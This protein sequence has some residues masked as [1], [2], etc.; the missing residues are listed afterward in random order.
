M[1][2]KFVFISNRVSPV[3][4]AL[5]EEFPNDFAS[6]VLVARASNS[7][8][9]VDSA[10]SCLAPVGIPLFVL[11]E[12]YLKS[13]LFLSFL[14]LLDL[15]FIVVHSLHFLLPRQVL[16]A[17]RCCCLNL[18]PSLL[19]AYRGPNPW[20][21]QYYDEQKTSGFTVHKMTSQEDAGDIILQQ[22]FPM[23]YTMMQFIFSEKM[24]KEVGAPLLCSAIRN[25]DDITPI[26]QTNPQQY[27][28]ARNI[29][30]YQN[31]PDIKKMTSHQIDIIRSVYPDFPINK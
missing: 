11:T 7:Q 14:Q 21:W 16:E 25:Y 4:P 29:V 27:R 18:H 22:E 15:D 10:V 24:L 2:R 3:L 5:A 20:F 1:N 19:P 26:H 6:F 23:D 9:N 13:V 17:P 31:D 28:R 30:D 12:Q 8:L